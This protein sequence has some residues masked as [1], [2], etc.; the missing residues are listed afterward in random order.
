MLSN[1][2]TF[3]RSL[4][5]SCPVWSTNT[6]DH[7]D[8]YDVVISGG[9]M[10]GAAMAA[11]LGNNPLFDEKRILLLEGAPKK[12]LVDLPQHFSNRTCA[13]SPA[14]IK[15]LSGFGA[16]DTITSMRCQ[17]VK[18]M[19]VWDSAADSLITFNQPDLTDNL[20]FIVEN[21]V[22]LESIMRQL[23]R[24]KDNVEVCYSSKVTNYQLPHPGGFESLEDAKP[25]AG[26]ELEG[27]EKIWTKLLIGADG[28]KSLLR[29]TAKIH[30]VQ[31]D[32]DQ[33]GVVATVNI[34][35]TPDNNIAWQRFLKTGPIALLP[36]SS[37]YCSLIWSTSRDDAKNLD[38]LDEESFADAVNN[39]FWSDEL[40]DPVADYA[41]QTLDNFLMGI[42]L[43]SSASR[44]LPPTV[45]GIAP[46]SRAKFPLGLCHASQYVKTRVALIGDAAHRV[47]PMAGQ[48]VNLGF[49][50]VA[51]LADRL[52]DAVYNGMDIGSINHLLEYETERQRTVLPVMA[53]T[54]G[55]KRLYGASWTPVVLARTIGLQATNAL[56][57]LK[58]RLMKQAMD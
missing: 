27:G 48:G 43:G 18:S 15:F 36:L 2:N 12:Q 19:Q 53:L 33:F 51:C 47:H 26:I 29:K 44:Q 41:S 35:E 3:V 25:F 20:A 16:W 1:R 5:R 49:G 45:I 57:P 24:I 42:G 6:S 30:T 58:D 10:V 54:D 4:H 38:K 7:G 11:A 23:E 46:G 21:D 32:Y 28:F 52:G 31:W 14:T 56:G 17:E 55:L 50:D 22:I 40:K 9:G 39:A 8:L 37:N 34:A 13:L